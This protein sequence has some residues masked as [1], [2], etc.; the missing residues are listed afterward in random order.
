[1]KIVDGSII[2]ELEELPAQSLRQRDE[3]PRVLGQ[4]G[5][6]V[7]ICYGLLVR[8]VVGVRSARPYARA[9]AHSMAS[10]SDCAR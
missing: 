1:M 8:R 9:R 3:M 5:S 7:P 10:A 6:L 4:R 2:A